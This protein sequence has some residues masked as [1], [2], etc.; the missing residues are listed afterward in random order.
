MQR[1]VLAIS[2]SLLGTP[3]LSAHENWPQ[4]RGPTQQGHT[5][6]K[7]LPVEFDDVKNVTWKTLIPGLGHSSPVVWENQVW[8]TTALEEGKSLHA[9][10]L[11]RETGKILH[12]IQVF[13]NETT[14]PVNAKN[15]HASPSP[16]IEA[17]RIYVHFGTYGTA[18]LETATGKIIWENRNLKLEHQEGPGSSPILF[19]NLLIVNCDGCDVRY[20]IALDKQTGETVWKTDR[21]GGL[22]SNRDTNKAFSTPTLITWKGDPLMI[23]PGAKTAVAYDPRNGKEIWWSRYKG[24]SVVPRPVTNSEAVFLT[25][26]YMKPELHAIRLGGTGD[27]TEKNLLWKS[28]SQIPCNSSLLLEGEELYLVSDAGIASCLNQKT[29]ELLWKERLN[30]AFWS[31]PFDAGGKIYFCGEKGSVTVLKSGKKL[32]RLARNQFPSGIFATPAIAGEAMF[33]RTT[34]AIYR[35]EQK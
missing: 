10:C 31:S 26:G 11:D 24:F 9:V 8:V 33:L 22:D 16:V 14:V 19:E 23:D 5:D 30:D 35:I 7:N 3:F 28:T 17:G 1:I 29:G 25:T 18:C 12:N 2:L 4:F 21:P 6:A 32:E 27:V 13:T 15:S 20:V 34:E